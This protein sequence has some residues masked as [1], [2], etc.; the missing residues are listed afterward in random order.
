MNL[1]MA[2]RRDPRIGCREL[3]RRDSHS[4]YAFEVVDD[5]IGALGSGQCSRYAL[6]ASP[7]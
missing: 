5:L 4:S 3:N 2:S 6:P 1:G 7:S